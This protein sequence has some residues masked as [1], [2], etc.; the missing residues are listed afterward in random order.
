MLTEIS[1]SAVI[2]LLVLVVYLLKLA[3][4]QKRDLNRFQGILDVEAEETKVKT[5]L[6]KEQRNYRQKPREFKNRKPRPN[7]HLP[8]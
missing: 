4:K 8:R 5:T 2:A 6:E 3:I 1:V 7:V